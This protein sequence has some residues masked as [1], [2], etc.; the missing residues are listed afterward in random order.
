MKKLILTLS[1][2]AFTG[3]MSVFT[4]CDAI[5]KKAKEEAGIDL[6][7]TFDGATATFDIPVIN[8]LNVTSYPDTVEVPL[9]LTSQLEAYSNLIGMGD[10]T[11]VTVT[12][13]ELVIN[14]SDA[15]NDRSNFYTALAMLYTDS[16]PEAIAISTNDE[17]PDSP[18]SS[19]EL[20]P[21]PGINLLDYMK[22]GTKIYYFVGVN[23]RKV[24][25]KVLNCTLKIKYRVQ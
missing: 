14:N 18:G 2:L 13:M 16:K 10:V 1:L 21:S 4:S 8:T 24:T 25:T 3:S 22:S 15:S 20:I 11:S 19:I 12:E 17:V 9:E 6:D 5:K 23:M 7:F